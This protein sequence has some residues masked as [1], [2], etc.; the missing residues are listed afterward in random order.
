MDLEGIDIHGEQQA[1]EEAQEPGYVTRMREELAQL[2]ERKEK[3]EMFLDGEK[4]EEVS[5]HDQ[6]LL[7]GQLI[8]MSN[9]H[10]FLELR[11]DVWDERKRHGVE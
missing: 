5:T 3:L 8:A 7:I 11:V 4:F 10:A 2:V 1:A 6:K 9:Y